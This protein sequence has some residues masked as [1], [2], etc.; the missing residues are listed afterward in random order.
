MEKKQIPIFRGSIIWW[1]VLVYYSCLL[2]LFCMGLVG[3]KYP[4]TYTMGIVS[5]FLVVG[6]EIIIEFWVF[7]H[8]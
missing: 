5:G 3:Q 4:T 6:A 8:G 1:A 7:K 2:L